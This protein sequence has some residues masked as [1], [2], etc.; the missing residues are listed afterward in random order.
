[1]ISDAVL[2]SDLLRVYSSIKTQRSNPKNHNKEALTLLETKKSQSIIE[3]QAI[4]STY[5]PSHK[6]K[7]NFLEY[8]E[9]YVRLNKRK[10]NRHRE[11]SLIQFKQFID[12]DFISSTDI[13][14]NFC[15]RFRQF[16]MDR[17][18]GETPANYYA[19]FKWVVNAATSD[20]YFQR[21]PTEHVAGKSKLSKLKSNLEVEEYLMLLNTP[22]FNEEVQAAF[23]LLYGA[24]MGR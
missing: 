14:E 16:L 7:T 2:V 24:A 20:S 3:K 6:F 17:Y 11:C 4:G 15:K 9:E 8:Y 23:L 21:N 13:T 1:M 18:T 12:K 19:R 10:G 22:S 5:I